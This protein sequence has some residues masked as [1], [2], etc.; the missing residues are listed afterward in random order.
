[1][2]FLGFPGWGKERKGPTGEGQ[3]ESTPQSPHPIVTEACAE[4]GFGDH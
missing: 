1:M 3:G 4:L 2:A